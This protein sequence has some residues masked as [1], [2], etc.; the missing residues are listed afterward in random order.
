MVIAVYELGQECLRICIYW[1]P[2]DSRMP[3]LIMLTFP[4]ICFLP[5]IIQAAR[6]SFCPLMFLQLMTVPSPNSA[7]LDPIVG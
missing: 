5:G 4:A 7:I 1:L 6:P 3:L 2:L